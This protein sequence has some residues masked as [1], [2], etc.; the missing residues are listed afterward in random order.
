MDPL[1]I[2]GGLLVAAIVAV[3]GLL[4]DRFSNPIR[5]HLRYNGYS[6]WRLTRVTGPGARD[7]TFTAR[8]TAPPKWEMTG[9]DMPTSNAPFS[10][11]STL[12]RDQWRD[13]A[14]TPENR[15]FTLEWVEWSGRRHYEFYIF[16]NTLDIDVRRR[17]VQTPRKTRKQNQR[18]ARAMRQAAG[19]SQSDD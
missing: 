17:D 9:G 13:I 4:W 15:N 3:C 5:W 19:A 7:L 11:R 8:F 16:T 12:S 18:R 2:L 10:P 1:G 14:W 6:S